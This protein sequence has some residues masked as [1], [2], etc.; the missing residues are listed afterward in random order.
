MNSEAGVAE[1]QQLEFYRPLFRAVRECGRPVRL[2][3]RYKGVRPETI[4]A[5]TSLG[6]DVTLSTKF[7]C[8]HMG[9]PYHPTVAD[10]LYRTSRYSFGAMLAQPRTYHV[11]YQLWSVGSQRL[12]LWGDPD[13]A[14]RFARS[15]RLGDGD[16]F[17]VFA[18]LTNKGFGN[19]PGQWQIFAD[20]AYESGTWEHEHYWFFYLVF[21][22]LGYNPQSDP[23]TWR[24]ELRGRFGEAADAVET[25]YRQSS[26]ILP[27]LTVTR[28]LSASEWS[29]WPEMDTGD[30]LPEYMVIQPSDTAQ[31]YAI[32]TWKRTPHW[33]GEAWD[34]NIP[35]YVEDAVAGRLGAKW[36]PL[37]VSRRLRDLAEGTLRGIGQAHAKVRDPNAA[38]FRATELDLRVLAQLALYHAEKTQAA[39]DLAFFEL[40]GESGRLP[41]A[42]QHM[43]EALAAWEQIVRL[44]GGVYH[45]NLVFGHS[46][47]H[48]RRQGHHH[49]GHWKDRLPE[50]RDDVAYLEDVL[51]KHRDSRGPVRVFPG[52][53]NAT[54][55]PR[56]EHIPVQAARPGVDL[57]IGVRVSGEMAVRQVVLHYRPLNQAL[58][59]KQLAMRQVTDGGFR[60]TVPGQ[61]ISPGWDLQYYF[62]VLTEGGGGRLW[63]CW[64]QGAPYVVAK[65]D[66]KAK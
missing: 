54:K 55:A 49:S 58:D 53:A 35:G 30:R 13:Y 65:V 46:P 66:R 48:K 52:E 4:E 10:R 8:E 43:R 14:A 21:G 33:R 18:P 25:A 61:E 16:G 44:T 37:Q 59:W 28:Q 64:E 15:C 36:T 47:Q 9:L 62:E 3:L 24:R 6:L 27:L 63:P 60:V 51:H 12:L 38:E 41:R 42:L 19:L 57:D 26:Q 1:E 17:E 32:R 20:R 39:T 31:F 50:V 7:W 5:A 29:W 22:R 23:E 34:E 45:G 40:T 11:V 56:V 2:D